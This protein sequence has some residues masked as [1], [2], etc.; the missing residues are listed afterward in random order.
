MPT[1][2][3]LAALRQ[4]GQSQEDARAQIASSA[5]ALAQAAV[6]G[7]RGWYSTDAITAWAAQLADDITSF[8]A[9]LASTVDAF[10]ATIIGELTGVWFQPAGPIDVTTLRAGV[11]PAGTYA[12][13]ADVY[14]WQ[15]SRLDHAAMALLTDPTPQLPTLQSPQDAALGRIGQ[16]VEMD[17]ALV[18]RGQSR[19]TMQAAAGKG[20]ITGWRRVLHPEKAKGGSC[21]L[22]IAASD[23]IYHVADLMPLHEG[24]NCQ[25]MPITA[26]HDP[27][28]ELNAQDMAEVYA[29]AG[30]TG[31]DQ[32]HRTRIQVNQHGE[33]GPILAAPGKVRGPATVAKDT[34]PTPRRPQTP[35][36]KLAKVRTLHDS[37]ARSLVKADELATEDPTKW[38]PYRDGL[39]DRVN[40]LEQELAA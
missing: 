12:R 6:A 37:L 3:D 1:A 11:T 27:G 36:E 29:A 24:C 9:G 10:V 30:G 14:R 35:A 19:A 40:D 16:L 22:C 34:N 21:G 31:R 5:V 13:A 17:T 4:L 7:F 8:L 26:T 20:R 25:T 23:R 15:Q 2:P 39:A 33:L 32:L 38:A 28:R 18:S